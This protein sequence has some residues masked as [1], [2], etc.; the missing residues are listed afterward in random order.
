MEVLAAAA[1]ARVDASAR[2]MERVVAARE[3][4]AVAEV[5]ARAARARVAE[6][7]V[8][9]AEAPRLGGAGGAAGARVLGDDIATCLAHCFVEETDHSRD[10][11]IV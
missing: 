6:A 5:V 4:V 10:M 2:A 3:A 7:A 11:R 1:A 9:A 8:A